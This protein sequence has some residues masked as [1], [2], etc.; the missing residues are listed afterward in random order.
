MEA[1]DGREDCN[2]NQTTLQHPSGNI[3]KTKWKHIWKTI[4][5]HLIFRSTSF[6]EFSALSVYH[7]DIFGRSFAISS[8]KCA[9]LRIMLWVPIEKCGLQAPS[10][11]VRDPYHVMYAT[12]NLIHNMESCMLYRGHY[13]QAIFADR[14]KH[15]DTFSPDHTQQAVRTGVFFVKFHFILVLICCNSISSTTSSIL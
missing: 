5:I 10:L 12:S 3:V 1:C 7:A 6:W 9:A 8:S 4:W 2:D 11:S 15:L 14:R 13:H